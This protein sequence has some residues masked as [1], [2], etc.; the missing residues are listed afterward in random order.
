MTF[1]FP[2]FEQI[3]TVIIKYNHNKKVRWDPSFNVLNLTLG[4]YQ[5][6]YWIFCVLSYVQYHVFDVQYIYKWITMG[7]RSP[8]AIILY[9]WVERYRMEWCFFD[10]ETTQ[11]QGKVSKPQHSYLKPK[12]L[13]TNHNTFMTLYNGLPKLPNVETTLYLHCFYS[14]YLN[15]PSG[16]WLEHSFLRDTRN[17]VQSNLKHARKKNFK[18]HHNFIRAET[19]STF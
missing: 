19:L 14:T 16:L 2:S 12:A 17:N 15:F 8:E 7:S 3:N 13:T 18:T 6:K 4:E 9:T 10:N 11:W 1:A 5:K